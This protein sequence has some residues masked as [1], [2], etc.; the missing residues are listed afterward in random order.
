MDSDGIL[1]IIIRG[2]SAA[3]RQAFGLKYMI[4]TDEVKQ[5]FKKPCFFILPVS[6]VYTPLLNKRAQYRS[7]LDIHYF[8]S[9]FKKNADISEVSEKLYLV[10]EYI[11]TDC[12][13]IRGT[14]INEERVDGVLH[15]I[16]DYSVV[17]RRE[18]GKDPYMEVLNINEA[19]G[20]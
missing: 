18:K 16:V 15:F 7:R 8:S 12:G 13:L 20:K 10:L 17:T 5:G 14:G 9:G 1:N 3:L 4:Y 11:E 19:V 2:V 6:G